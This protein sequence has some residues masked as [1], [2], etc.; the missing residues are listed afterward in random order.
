[1]GNAT[2]ARNLALRNFVETTTTLEQAEALV[3]SALSLAGGFGTPC[4]QSVPFLAVPGL[5]IQTVI[6]V[7]YPKGFAVAVK[8]A[9]VP[10][11]SAN[12]ARAVSAL[13]QLT[14]VANSGSGVKI[15]MRGY[16]RQRTA[17]T[18]AAAGCQAGT[19]WRYTLD[20][21]PPEY[22]CRCPANALH[23]DLK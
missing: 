17:S 9:S 12:F 15:E 7:V 18:R 3:A 8:T 2:L 22:A 16:A 21:A 1:M 14:G 13:T 11:G 6:G 20:G 23:K 10:A 5:I 19:E 4:N